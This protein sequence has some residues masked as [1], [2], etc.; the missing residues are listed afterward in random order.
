MGQ[1]VWTL[2]Q[3]RPDSQHRW[4]PSLFSTCFFMGIFALDRCCVCCGHPRLARVWGKPG[5]TTH[6]TG[7]LG[8][9]VFDHLPAVQLDK[10]SARLL[11]RDFVP[12]RG[13]FLRAISGPVAQGLRPSPAFVRNTNCAVR[14]AAGHGAWHGAVYRQGGGP[15]GAAADA[16]A[17]SGRGSAAAA[18]QPRA[19]G[20]PAAGRGSAVHQHHAAGDTELFVS[21]PGLQRRPGPGSPDAWPDLCLANAAGGA[22]VGP[23]QPGVLPARAGQRRFTARGCTLLPGHPCCRAGSDRRNT[24]AGRA[25]GAGTLG[26]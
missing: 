5:R 3:H 6:G 23:V 24:G 21:G 19:A 2:F 16:G 18:A 7:V 9:L 13:Y 25:G 12:L 20:V 14:T 26:T 4:Q 11:R 8:C 1:P 17:G 15:W 22:R 10:L